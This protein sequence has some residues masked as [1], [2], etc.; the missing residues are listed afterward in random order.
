MQ[1][2]YL[3]KGLQVQTLLFWV[4]ISNTASPISILLSGALPHASRQD[5]HRLCS[6]PGAEQRWRSTLRTVTA[7]P[8]QGRQ[9][10]AA[11]LHCQL[12]LQQLN[13][14]VFT[15]SQGKGSLCQIVKW[16]ACLKTHSIYRINWRYRLFEHLPK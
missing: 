5:S 6:P 3:D 15:C 7:A 10:L 8:Q 12:E 14:C 9:A 13:S 11:V 16:R 4:S 1:K 2:Y